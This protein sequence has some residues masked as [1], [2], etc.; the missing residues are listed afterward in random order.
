[1]AIYSTLISNAHLNPRKANVPL[2][3]TA[4]SRSRSLPWFPAPDGQCSLQMGAARAAL[5]RSV[6]TVIHLPATLLQL[7]K[8]LLLCSLKDLQKATQIPL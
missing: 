4:S 1:M 3:R 2:W 7:S 5:S 6:N 8:C